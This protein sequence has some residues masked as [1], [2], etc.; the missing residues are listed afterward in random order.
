MILTEFYILAKAS[1]SGEII[2][3]VSL[4]LNKIWLIFSDCISI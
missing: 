1:K 2:L 3:I 4:L